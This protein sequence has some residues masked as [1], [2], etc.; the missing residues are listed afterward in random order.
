MKYKKKPIV[1]EAY[2]TDKELNI[3]TLEGT[4][5][6]RAGDYIITGVSGEQ[7]P[8]KPDIFKKTYEEITEEI[9]DDD[10]ISRQAA[11]KA[12]DDLPNCYNGY[13]DTYDKACIIGVLEE[14]PPIEP[15]R[16]KWIYDKGLYRCTACNNLLTVAGWDI[17]EEQIYKSFKFCPNCGA[18]MERSE[19]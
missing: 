18:Q 16:G 7:Y 15:K 8:C 14:L 12:I 17:P 1:I 11:I 6:A 5:H 19:K 3:E 2:Q 4:M 10:L 13:S 9:S